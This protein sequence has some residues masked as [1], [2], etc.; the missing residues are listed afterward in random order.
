[1]FPRRQF[2]HD[3]AVFR[4]DPALGRDDVG[5]HPPATDDRGT[6]FVT[7]SFEGKKSHGWN[8]AAPRAFS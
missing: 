5:E 7:G 8:A 6:G 3:A 4:V 2:G 1:M